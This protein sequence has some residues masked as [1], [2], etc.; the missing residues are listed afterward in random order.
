[1]LPSRFAKY[2]KNFKWVDMVVM[3]TNAIPLA[4]LSS[5][6]ADSA[7]DDLRRG[8]HVKAPSFDRS[9]STAVHSGSCGPHPVQDITY[10]DDPAML[11]N[12][13]DLNHAAVK[14]CH[15]GGDASQ[16]SG[17]CAC[18]SSESS[19]SVG[20]VLTSSSSRIPNHLRRLTWSKMVAMATNS[21]LFSGGAGSGSDDQDRS[22]T[23]A[24]A[25]HDSNGPPPGYVPRT[26]R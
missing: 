19:I 15:H 1:M 26:D 21:A 2:V 3:A 9:S 10:A 6:G 4:V 22:S 7:R 18:F 23:H 24:A 5:S 8:A 17:I 25:H 14:Q 12:L 16:T 20:L 11:V 13:P